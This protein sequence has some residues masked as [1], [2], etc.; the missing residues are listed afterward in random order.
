MTPDAAPEA[1][2][3]NAHPRRRLLV[4]TLLSALLALAVVVAVALVARGQRVQTAA[5]GADT[6]PLLPT[7]GPPAEQMPLPAMTL[8]A[9][10]GFA[11]PGGIDLA[12]VR[13]QPMVIN[14]WAS[15][16][17]PCVKEMPALQRVADETGVT[18]IGVAYIDQA[19]KARALA[20]QL[21]ITYDLVRDDEGEF[22]ERIGLLGTP[23]TLLVDASGTVVRQLTGELNEQQMRD[24]V[25]FQLRDRDR[26]EGWR[27]PPPIGT[28][29]VRPSRVTSTF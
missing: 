13:G 17:A 14:F 23:T 19:D 8:P 7:E 6:P 29:A 16:C 9:L 11:P 21:D 12:D 27:Q 3:H 1:S 2:A 4:T 25:E 26:A 22:G 10:D 15:W 5:S 18:V 28:V 20:E 24:A